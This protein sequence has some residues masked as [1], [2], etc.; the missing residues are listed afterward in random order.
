MEQST[1]HGRLDNRLARTAAML[2]LLAAGA[3]CQPQ[4]P[5]VKL[6]DIQLENLSL[7]DMAVTVVMDVYNPNGFDIELKTLD[8]DLQAGDSRFGSGKVAGPVKIAATDSAIVRVP[9]KVQFDDLVRIGRSRKTRAAIPYEISGKATFAAGGLDMTAPVHHAG[10]ILPLE[11]PRWHIHRI[12]RQAGH[13]AAVELVFEVTNPND[14]PLDV[15]GISGEI[16]YG[17]ES[18]VGLGSPTPRQLPASKM[19]EVVVPLRLSPAVAAKVIAG[20]SGRQ[21]K[22]EFSGDVS[23]TPPMSLRDLLLGKEMK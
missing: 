9:T 19:V 15:I 16:T 12:R 2:A 22:L 1:K 11:P 10:K 17:G 13:L 4:K 21:E 18:L 5:V 3:G 23:F 14:M 6:H 8:F 20:L 7:R